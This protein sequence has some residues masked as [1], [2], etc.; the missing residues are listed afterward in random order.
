M[1]LTLPKY[2]LAAR[3]AEQFEGISG[4]DISNAVLNAAFMA[5]RHGEQRISEDYFER[6]VKSIL[7]SKSANQKK[8]DVT[9]T[10]KAVSEEYVKQQLGTDN[11]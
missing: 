3:L 11:L 4:G 9:V 10:K 1:P 6:A 2:E 7:T 8:G 5:A